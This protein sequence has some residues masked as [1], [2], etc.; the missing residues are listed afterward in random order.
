MLHLKFRQLPIQVI[1]RTG[2]RPLRH[3][4]NFSISADFGSGDIHT[5]SRHGLHGPGYVCLPE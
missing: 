2:R 5:G 3:Y 1:L 4:H